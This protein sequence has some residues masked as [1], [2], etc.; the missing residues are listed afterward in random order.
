MTK[1]N[2]TFVTVL[3]LFVLVAGLTV[4]LRPLI[5]LTPAVHIDYQDTV[6]R[7]AKEYSLEPAL[8]FAV[9]KTESNFDPLAR[10]DKN[11]YGLMQITESTLNWALFREGKGLTY[12]AAD[13]Y[14]PKI[15]IKYGCLLL[16]LLLEEFGDTD[17]ALA[18]YNAGRSNVLK[19][20][21]DSRYSP[22]GKRITDAPYEETARYI[23]KVRKNQ[24]K[25]Q[26]M[27]GENQ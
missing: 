1:H 8:V 27:L 2:K 15:N 18:A 12:T 9:I 17:T 24:E 13:L 11:A 26:Q 10:S 21:K 14:E 16:S 4:A 20:L 25:Y 22:D 19:W 5:R 23:E 7:Y 6:F 3:L